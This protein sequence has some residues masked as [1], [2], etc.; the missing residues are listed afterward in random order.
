[1]ENN[2]RRGFLALLLAVC[3]LLPT[4]AQ[5]AD[6]P[7]N[8][9]SYV[10]V[11]R[12]YS[13]REG[14]YRLNGR[15]APYNPIGAGGQRLFNFSFTG[16]TSTVNGLAVSPLAKLY[17]FVCPPATGIY[18]DV[19]QVGWLPAGTFAADSPAYIKLIG[20]P[21]DT[22]QLS[23]DVSSTMGHLCFPWG[24]TNYDNDFWD[25]GPSSG[26]ST[27]NM[28]KKGTF[29]DDVGN[30]YQ[31]K[32]TAYAPTTHT[33]VP[34]WN[35]P[36]G[37]GI[38]HP[39]DTYKV[40]LPNKWGGISWYCF[41]SPNAPAAHKGK[42][43]DG[44]GGLPLYTQQQ[45]RLS[46]YSPGPAC[47]PYWDAIYISA[48]VR[49]VYKKRDRSLDLYSY[50]DNAAPPNGM[51]ALEP[52]GAGVLTATDLQITEEYGKSCADGCIPGG[53][54]NPEAVAKI[55]SNVLVIT[56]TTGR[57]YGFNPNGDKTS[58]TAGTNT[59]LR[60]VADG[61]TY[62]IAMNGTGVVR[63]MAHLTSRGFNLN[64]IK[65]MGVSSNFNPFVAPAVGVNTLSTPPD[66]IYGSPADKFVVQDSWWGNGGIAYEYYKQD[67]GTNL[68]GHIYRY[69]YRNSD[70]P[71]REDVGFFSGDIDALGV[72]GYGTLY[73][74]A[75]ELDCANSPDWPDPA[76]VPLGY[77]I[78]AV[79][80]NAAM[81]ADPN[82]LTHQWYR[83][84]GSGNNVTIAGPSAVNDFCVVTFK[85]RIKKQGRKY[86]TNIGG[87]FQ[88]PEDWGFV[89]VGFDEIQRNL[90]FDGGSSYS[91]A[92]AWN[93]K[94]TSMDSRLAAIEGEFAVI[95][96]A[97]APTN[98]IAAS[99][100]RCGV[101]RLNKTTPTLTIDPGQV[102]TED[103][104]CV[105]KPEGYKPLLSGNYTDLKDM[106]VIVGIGRTRVNMLPPYFFNEDGLGADGGFTDSLFE[107]D[108][109]THKTS[110]KWNVSLVD[111]SGTL[112]KQYV[113]NAASNYASTDPGFVGAPWNATF[114]RFQRYKYTF[115]QP[116]NYKVWCEVT[117]KYFDYSALPT[118]N[119]R[120]S[121]LVTCIRDVTIVGTPVLFKVEN[122]LA[123]N[124]E[125]RYLSNLRLDNL[126][127]AQKT[128]PAF[129][130]SATGNANAPVYDVLRGEPLTGL[131][132]SFDVQMV[133]DANRDTSGAFSTFDGIGAWDYDS[134]FVPPTVGGHVYNHVDATNFNDTFNPG[135]LAFSGLADKSSYGTRV[136]E[137]TPS[138]QPYIDNNDL[139]AM[140]W[141]LYMYPAY[142]L[143]NSNGTAM[144]PTSWS[145]PVPVPP[146]TPG[147]ALS[148][149]SDA[150][151]ALGLLVLSGNCFG[152]TVSRNAATRNYHVIV[153]I[154]PTVTFN[155][156]ADP[157]CYVLRPEIEA[158]RVKWRNV[159]TVSD[160]TK[161][162]YYSIVP[163]LDAAGNH[164]TEV[165]THYPRIG[166]G[167]V[168][169]NESFEFTPG[170]AIL[171]HWTVRVHD[172]LP[173]ESI[174]EMA[175]MMRMQTT[176]DPVEPA[177]FGF[178]LRDDNP[179]AEFVG[180]GVEY[181]IPTAPRDPSLKTWASPIAPT[182]A[183]TGYY[184][185]PYALPPGP[186]FA[187]NSTYRITASFTGIIARYGDNGA[188]SHSDLFSPDC[189]Y[190]NWIGSLTLSIKGD[191]RD[192]YELTGNTMSVHS[193]GRTA[194]PPLNATS[195]SLMRFDND[196]PS[197]YLDIVAASENK[198]WEFRAIENVVDTRCYPKVAGELSSI[199][200]YS[201][202][203]T[204]DGTPLPATTVAT[205]TVPG[206]S[207]Y[208]V[209]G[210]GVP[211]VDIAAWPSARTK[212]PVVKKS[213]RIMVNAMVL[214]NVDYRPTGEPHVFRNARLIVRNNDPVDG[215]RT[216]FDSSASTETAFPLDP[217]T[218]NPICNFSPLPPLA[219]MPMAPYGVLNS[220]FY[221]DVPQR[222]LPAQTPTTTQ[223]LELTMSAT[224]SSGNVRTLRVPIIVVETNFDARVLESS[225]SKR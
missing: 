175:S 167:R 131:K 134:I 203:R 205:E 130:I 181:E 124:P 28:Y 151:P 66:F 43:L 55:E 103:R 146:A 112:I 58:G 207:D 200:L 153:N 96:I 176:G 86:K 35:G 88:P 106:G 141:R 128:L 99:S 78:G 182:T 166:D 82:Y 71:N 74:L 90:R 21:H 178:T 44:T 222:V 115:P 109:G 214:D 221:I 210:L 157:A 64:G 218:T 91:W 188:P 41:G 77:T 45:F 183:L 204:L 135:R 101:V 145:P 162:Q 75:T 12:D 62:G 81:L 68:K 85:Q 156:P 225:E 1:M 143:T 23:P 118:V 10:L 100:G 47:S 113:T 56:S 185:N 107:T 195:T 194:P 142:S 73:V 11:P 133:R 94:L 5:A 17:L 219:G 108:S 138:T 104:D 164:R 211:L 79:W 122:A 13:G 220:R 80:P 83:V 149:S 184:S 173:V 116:G 29:T 30:G 209:A 27:H 25:Y 198:R 127:Y 159:Q 14:V 160:A 212:I 121:D 202:A 201:A 224:D 105:F 70:T 117:H 72:D 31:Y 199:G 54:L 158:P 59:A 53:D 189:N 120:P 3:V 140:K 129:N 152:A 36:G 16:G 52:G 125:P 6:E 215:V 49:R 34:L 193:Y 18:T 63:N 111:Q 32:F 8:G 50:L 57:R 196:P 93:H 147:T 4:L 144:G 191:L 69:D 208:P 197:L 216:L 132:L 19:T 223:Q 174:R 110:I 161:G 114:D 89:D 171:D 165:I 148:V 61:R 67:N 217:D 102:I 136:D 20:Q 119:P 48:V 2:K 186:D 190:T 97:T 155:T 168:F 180:F 187:L 60:V 169:N 22:T 37:V 65:T 26:F 9:I 177:T 76:G 87:G 170:G 139:R 92:N 192:G 154:P 213:T 123:L 51:P 98:T 172:N 46:P 15:I 126:N 95:N 42:L 206:S 179:T 40:V 38:P 33:N 137:V 84:D 24:T 150:D 7:Y 39:T 163:D